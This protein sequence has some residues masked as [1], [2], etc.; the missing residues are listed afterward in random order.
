M[1]SNEPSTPKQHQALK[2]LVRGDCVVVVQPADASGPTAE[3]LSVELTSGKVR[4]GLR[5]FLRAGAITA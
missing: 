5:G 1:A 2:L 4:T 3:T